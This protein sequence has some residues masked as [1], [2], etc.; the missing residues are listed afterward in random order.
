MHYPVLLKEVIEKLDLETGDVILDATLGGGGHAKDILGKILPGGKL[1]AVDRDPEAIERG[2]KELADFKDSVIFVKEDFRNIEKVL[3]SPGAASID[4]AIFDLGIS[5]FQVDDEKRGFS[6]LKDGPLDMRFDRSQ[7][8][9]AKDVVNKSS[10]EE[11]ADIIKEYGEERHAKLV[12]GAICSSRKRKKI[13]TTREL[14]DIVLSAIGGKYRR[15]KLHPAARTFQALRICTND[16]LGAVG[17]GIRKAISFLSAGA[18]ICV[19]AFHS[20]EDRIVKNI[21]KEMKKSGELRIIT[22]KP[23]IPGRDEVKANPRSRSAKLRVAE[24]TNE[25][26]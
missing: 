2:K 23:I 26:L 16:E 6:F 8:L 3:G 19:I 17:E 22:K 24:K 21:F 20:L 5:S 1:I 4:G 14:A 18:R 15:Q 13:E 10:R 25:N 7:K 9:S 11:L 12:A